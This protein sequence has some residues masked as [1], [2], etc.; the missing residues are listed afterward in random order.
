MCGERGME[1]GPGKG[2]L[3]GAGSHRDVSHILERN[4]FQFGV[5][6]AELSLDNIF[7]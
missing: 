1:E 6:K 4:H 5:L 3:R 2:K 7:N